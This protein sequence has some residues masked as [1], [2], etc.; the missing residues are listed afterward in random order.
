MANTENTA[1]LQQ[2]KLRGRP[3]QKGVSGN[4]KGK[5]KGS[6]SFRTLFD[7][8]LAKVKDPKTNKA[9]SEEDLIRVYIE[10][11]VNGDNRLL[12]RLIDR[13]YGKPKEMETLT[14]VDEIGKISITVDYGKR[15]ETEEVV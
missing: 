13:M 4:P 3:F 8:A 10:R 5:P 1:K 14:P 15:P 7:L 11:A 2:K 9:Y 12:E 6:K